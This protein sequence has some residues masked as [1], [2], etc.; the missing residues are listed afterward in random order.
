LIR[1]ILAIS[2]VLVALFATSTAVASIP[3][4]TD[5]EVALCYKTSGGSTNGDA[6]IIDAEASETCPSGFVGP[7]YLLS[8]QAPVPVHEHDDLVGTLHS[9]YK[10]SST[11]TIPAGPGGSQVSHTASCDSGDAV[12]SGGWRVGD[13][14]TADQFVTI[15]SMPDPLGANTPTGWMARIVPPVL[16]S[17]V[18]FTVDVL[19]AEVVQ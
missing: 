13:S 19:C 17:S 1:K 2:A 8:D 7:V 6:K 4:S 11:A 10:R 18:P 9:A 3:N 12:L 14:S 15:G 16:I 5:G